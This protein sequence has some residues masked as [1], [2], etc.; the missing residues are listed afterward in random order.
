M[1]PSKTGVASAPSGSP[2]HAVR[3]RI[4]L[5]ATGVATISIPGER[6]E[7]HRKPGWLPWDWRRGGSDFHHSQQLHFQRWLVL[8]CENTC[9]Q[10][11]HSFEQC[12]GMS[13]HP[14]IRFSAG[15]FG[16]WLQVVTIQPA[17]HCTLPSSGLNTTNPNYFLS[18]TRG[19]SSDYHVHPCRFFLNTPGLPERRHPVAD[20]RGSR[21][22]TGVGAAWQP[23]SS[24]LLKK[25]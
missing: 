24:A 22:Q 5:E 11:K 1:V 14:T 19:S 2:F 16:R 15:E 18:T 6:E 13:D 20:Q 21:L 23:T 17:Q 9:H 25:R 8:F 4:T 12:G 7:V 10:Q 3:I